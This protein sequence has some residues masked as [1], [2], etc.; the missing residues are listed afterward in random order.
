MPNLTVYKGDD[1]DFNLTLTDGDNNTPI[2]ITG[3]T[4]WFTVKENETDADPG[5]LQKEITSHTSPTTGQ[6]TISLSNSDTGNLTPAEYYYDIQR[7]T[8]AAKVQT[9]VKGRFI[10]TQDITTSIS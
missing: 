7:V 6:T 3:D 10:V 2:N 9:L 4:I 1:K 8:A 5:V